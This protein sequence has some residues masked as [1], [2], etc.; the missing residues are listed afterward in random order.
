MEHFVQ[1]QQ[2]K[3]SSQ[4]VIWHSFL[5]LQFPFAI[6]SM[7]RWVSFVLSCC[8]VQLDL[9]AGNFTVLIRSVCS[10][11]KCLPINTQLNVH[12]ANYLKPRIFYI[13]YMYKCIAHKTHGT[14]DA[15][16]VLFAVSYRGVSYQQFQCSRLSGFQ[17]ENNEA[18]PKEKFN[19]IMACVRGSDERR[20]NTNTENQPK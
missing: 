16:T 18:K 4:F 14:N 8:Y 6:V 7:K 1:E 5:L 9:I 2:P 10:S 17:G 3:L 20:N 19:F 13:Y 11:S 12:D 15:Y